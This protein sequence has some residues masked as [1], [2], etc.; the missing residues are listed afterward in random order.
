MREIHVLIVD[1]DKTI[2]EALE[3]AILNFKTKFS[4]IV[5]YSAIVYKGINAY[6]SAKEELLKTKDKID[7]LFID[8]NIGAEGNGINLL[9]MFNREKKIIFKILH[10][11]TGDSSVQSETHRNKVFDRFS[12]TKNLDSIKEAL[13]WYEE[14]ILQA[15]LFGNKVYFDSF[16]KYDY[17]IKHKELETQIKRNTANYIDWIYIESTGRD[18]YDI[19]YR[20]SENEDGFSIADRTHLVLKDFEEDNRLKVLRINN[21]LIV[22]L[23]W[24]TNIDL[25]DRCITFILPNSFKKKLQFNTSGERINEISN[26]FTPVVQSGIPSFLKN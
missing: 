23:L 2:A 12:R 24:V 9:K 19:C 14:E 18:H 10:S 22:N 4:N 1:D 6:I 13:E 3:D 5:V 21:Q 7:I 16:F 11:Y 26:L 17:T 15:V 8:Y 20:A 25:I